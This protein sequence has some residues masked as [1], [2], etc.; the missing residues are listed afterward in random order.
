MS[1]VWMLCSEVVI[2]HGLA[3]STP[4]NTEFSSRHTNFF[5]LE[6]LL[7][8]TA[9]QLAVF[10]VWNG[11]PM[12]LRL[13]LWTS[14]KRCL[15]NCALLGYYA[16]SSGNFLPTFRHNLSVPSSGPLKMGPTGCPE[17]SVRNNHYWLRN[18]PEERR[19]QLLDHLGRFSLL[20]TSVRLKGGEGCLMSSTVYRPGEVKV[21]WLKRVDRIF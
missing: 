12:C 5:L 14:G 3:R 15:E 10:E 2:R 18:S 4:S 21:R 7:Y 16:T 20:R 1:S 19:S 13:L 11:A 17:T 9:F 8:S 6:K